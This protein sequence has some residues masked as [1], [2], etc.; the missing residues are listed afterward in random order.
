MLMATI[1]VEWLQ[2]HRDRRVFWALAAGL[3]LGLVSVCL[4]DV[5][6]RIERRTIDSAVAEDRAIWL[7]QGEVGPHSSAHFGQYA[8]RPQAQL[9]SLDRGLFPYLGQAIWIEAHNQNPAEARNVEGHG[10][11]D[12]MAD[13]SVAWTLRT[14]V[15][16]LMILLAFRI[17]AGDHEEGR[18]RLQRVHGRGFLGIAVGKVVAIVAVASLIVI[19]NLGIGALSI[20]LEPAGRSADTAVRFGAFA[21]VYVIYALVWAFIILGVSALSRNGTRALVLLLTCWFVATVLSPRLIASWANQAFPPTSATEFWTSAAHAHAKGV[22][23]HAPA[24]ER[25][26]AL[27]R[28]TLQRYG[29]S[30]PSDLPVAFAGVALQASERHQALVYDK[31]WADHFAQEDRQATLMRRLAPFTPVLA[32]NALSAG[33]AGADLLHQRAFIQAAEQHRREVQRLLNEDLAKNGRQAGF[34]YNANRSLWEAV[35]TFLYE[36]PRLADL[37]AHYLKDFGV[38]CLWLV[39]AVLFGVGSAWWADRRA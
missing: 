35:P 2:M 13:V 5:Q 15:P 12:R 22:D 38:L 37:G 14:I 36:P 6:T 26:A 16:L 18:V 33:F 11:L 30:K 20:G 34:D 1:G 3:V 29:V 8:F 27:M 28:E 17:V 39:A 31:M 10:Q 21:A 9:A 19:P 7:G 32:L 25:N 4:G 23:G 24:S